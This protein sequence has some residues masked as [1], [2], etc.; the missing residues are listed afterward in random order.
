MKR[1]R[2]VDL[3]KTLYAPCWEDKLIAQLEAE[4]PWEEDH[5]IQESLTYCRSKRLERLH[6]IA[7][8]NTFIDQLFESKF[9]PKV[10]KELD[11]EMAVDRV[12]KV[13]RLEAVLPTGM[14]LE[15]R[16]RVPGRIIRLAYENHTHSSDSKESEDIEVELT[17]RAVQRKAREP[18]PH[19]EGARRRRRYF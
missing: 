17:I 8:A 6:R 18:R 10:F 19:G 4:D 13:R 14:L 5:E 1:K 12:T 15:M 7:S 3:V 2:I 16:A 9:A 11:F